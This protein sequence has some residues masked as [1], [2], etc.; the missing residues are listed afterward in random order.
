MVYVR[1]TR[2]FGDAKS[3]NPALV[4]R[5]L[6]AELL[7]VVRPLEWRLPLRRPLGDRMDR[8]AVDAGDADADDGVTG[9]PRADHDLVG[10]P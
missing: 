4:V 7:G 8:T 3:A 10:D 5:D 9:G 2:T 6:R 1:C